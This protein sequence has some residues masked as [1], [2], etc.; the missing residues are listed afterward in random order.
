MTGRAVAATAA[1][2]LAML[3]AAPAAADVF[4][5][6]VAQTAPVR[7]G[8]SGSYREIYVAERGEIF[9]VVERG[10]RDF[11]Y[12]VSLEDGTAGWVLGELVFPFEVVED[13]P[14]GFFTRVGRALRGALLGPSPVPYA[15]VEISFSAGILDEEG[16]FL[17]RPN[18]LI[19]PYLA[20][21]GFAGISPRAD[22]DL[23]LGGLGFCL[24]LSPGAVLGP[25]ASLSLG[26]AYVRPKADNFVDEEEALMALA[27]GGGIEVTLKKQITVRL[28]ARNWTL[29]DQNKA[30]SGQ[31]FSGGLAIFF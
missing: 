4:V 31:E 28:D 9:E 6:V 26:T 22:K 20:V 7:S 30:S 5:R 24:R 18:W 29:F 11:W 27:A 15:D 16:V 13:G 3:A 1:L 12:R 10:T 8:P 14:P 23:F 2:A 21:E 25:Y 19:D 17:L